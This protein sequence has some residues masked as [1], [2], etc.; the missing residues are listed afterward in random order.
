VTWHGQKLNDPHW[1]D[2]GAQVLAYTLA[3][4]GE[5]EED[6][7]IMLNMSDK[8]VEMELP[9]IPGLRWHCAV[10]TSQPP[11]ADIPDA[12]DQPKVGGN[13]YSLSARSV[14]VLEGR[15]KV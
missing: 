11:P 5:M 4:V 1:G 9:I 2:A 13:T 7:H 15:G 10:D 8:V 12:A 3:G 14:V 6:L